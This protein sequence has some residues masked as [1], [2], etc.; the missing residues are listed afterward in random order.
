MTFW[1][2]TAFFALAYFAVISRFSPLARSQKSKA[3]DPNLSTKYLKWLTKHIVL[4]LI[5]ASIGVKLT[6]F[7]INRYPRGTELKEGIRQP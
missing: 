5:G 6:E 7:L 2:L 4:Y 3:Y 1:T